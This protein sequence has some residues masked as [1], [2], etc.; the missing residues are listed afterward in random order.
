[1]EE[2]GVMNKPGCFYDV[3]EK[4]CSLCLHKHQLYTWLKEMLT[5]HTTSTPWPY[6]LRGADNMAS[7]KLL[8]K[9]LHLHI[10]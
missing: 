10:Q 4:G 8:E 9:L 2:L 6:T 1:M 7:F 5:G 3:N